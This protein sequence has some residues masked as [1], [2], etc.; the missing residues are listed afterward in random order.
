MP[1][2]VPERFKDSFLSTP[3]SFNG[4]LSSYI[5]SPT[6]SDAVN[7][8]LKYREYLNPDASY[9]SEVWQ[10]DAAPKS[11]AERDRG[12]EACTSNQSGVTGLLTTNATAYVPK[13][14]TWNAKESSL[15]YQVAGPELLSDGKKNLGNYLLALRT[16]VASC[17]WKSDLKNAKS[18][19]VMDLLE[20]NW[21]PQLCPSETVG[22][23]SPPRVFIFLRRQ[24]K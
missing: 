12:F 24:S 23:T 3:N 1:Y 2:P 20:P 10:I 8:W 4:N 9:E 14:P 13:P 7:N 16:D 19:M 5:F 11:F 15:S 21:R 17:L 22:S 18:R 6:T